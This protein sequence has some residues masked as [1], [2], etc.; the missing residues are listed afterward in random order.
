MIVNGVEAI[1]A[2]PRFEDGFPFG[3]G[4]DSVHGG[5]GNGGY[6]RRKRFA[7]KTHPHLASRYRDW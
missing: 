5:V 7:M 4:D 2:I 1:P 3:A 6:G